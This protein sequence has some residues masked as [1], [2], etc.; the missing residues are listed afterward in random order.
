MSEGRVRLFVAFELPALVRN[1]IRV[2]AEGLDVGGLRV[3]EAEQLHVTLCFLGW[4]AEN[5]VS[6][7]AGAVSE[8][9]TVGERPALSVG[10]AVW[11]P[12][13]R[14]R[15]LAVRL[16]DRDGRLSALQARLS[17][18]LQAGGWY[19]PE[20]RAYLPHITAA[21][22]GR[23]ANVRA[24]PVAGPSPLSFTGEHV[25]LFRSLLSPRGARYE[26]LASVRLG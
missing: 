3:L 14:P 9:V 19:E 15:V 6:E 1:A 24:G 12:P 7:V 16:E 25:T 17:E 18:R 13:R 22:A 8:V 20:R 5:E 10:E 26:A 4:Q 11:L 23:N 2:W 21:R